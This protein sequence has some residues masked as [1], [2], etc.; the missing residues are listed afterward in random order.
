MLAGGRLATVA[1]GRHPRRRRGAVVAV[2]DVEAGHGIEESGD[3]RLLHLVRH[4]PEG[5]ADTVVGGQIVEGFSLADTGD[6]LVHLLPVTVGE[7]DRSGLGIQ[8]VD[9]A[10][11]VVLLLRPGELVAADPVALVVGHRGDRHQAGLHVL[12]HLQTVDVVAGSL[13]PH[14]DPFLDHP[15]QV[16]RP[17]SVDRRIVGIGSLRQVD[18]RLGDV[19]EAP[20]TAGRAFAGLAGVQHVVGRGH[21]LGGV[22][23]TGSQPPEGTDQVH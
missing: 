23:G 19:Q 15:L 8:G 1:H 22:F 7:E 21:H 6:D 14:Q 11:P 5:V 2:G 3:A 4:H 17:L 10:H 18:L 16:L 20:G 12:S 13:L 9:L